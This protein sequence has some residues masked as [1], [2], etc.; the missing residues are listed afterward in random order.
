MSCTPASRSPQRITKV[1]AVVD[2]VE[3]VRL[4]EIDEEHFIRE[5]QAFVGFARGLLPAHAGRMH[6]SLGDGLMLEFA[7]ATGCLDAARAMLTWLAGRNVQAAADRQVYLRIGAHV[8][9]FVADDYDIYGTDVNLTARI[10]ALAGPGEIVVTAALRDRLPEAERQ[11]TEDLGECH[12]KHVR[13]PARLFRMGAAGP[14]PVLSTQGEAAALRPAICLLPFQASRRMGRGAEADAEALGDELLAA[15]VRHSDLQVLS[16]LAPAGT[17]HAC[18]HYL[19]N[20]GCR[21]LAGERRFF[22]ELVEAGTG[23]V[24]WASGAQSARAQRETFDRWLATRVV[25]A[26]EAAIVAN[27][28]RRAEGRS[29]HALEGATLLTA[30]IALLQRLTVVTMDRARE[31]LEQVAE[32]HRRHPAGYAWLA[33][34]HLL[35]VRQ[36]WT[37][38]RDADVRQALALCQQAVQ[39]DPRDPMAAAVRDVVR[40][41]LLHGAS[42]PALLA[43]L[44][45]LRDVSALLRRLDEGASPPPQA[46]APTSGPEASSSA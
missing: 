34:W 36:G 10:A 38:D 13:V 4:M 33:L 43:G 11:Q 16:R 31:M 20:G 8:A 39:C 27:E 35:R 45:V 46:I 9:A 1:I 40:A 25:P 29:V 19:L 26:I 18:A 12:L 14:A 23:R 17:A 28:L 3:S 30:A 37:Q 22:I 15:L 24:L 6:K 7:D 42:P 44:P 5:W 41:R 2:V 21:D 32:R